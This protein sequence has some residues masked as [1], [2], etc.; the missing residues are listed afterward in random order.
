MTSVMASLSGPAI[1]TLPLQL[2]FE[3]DLDDQDA[4]EARRKSART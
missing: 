2:N 3:G 4:P 1:L